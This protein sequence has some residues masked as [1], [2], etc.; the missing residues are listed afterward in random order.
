VIFVGRYVPFAI[1]VGSMGAVDMV[2]AEL[3][4]K[5]VLKGLI[6]LVI[7]NGILHVAPIN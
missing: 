6:L 7:S 2:D 1:M 3:L 4:K 5:G